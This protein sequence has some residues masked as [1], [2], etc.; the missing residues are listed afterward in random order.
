MLFLGSRIIER[1]EIIQPAIG[2]FPEE[3]EAYTLAKKLIVALPSA[4]IFAAALDLV[5]VVSYMKWI[6]PWCKIVGAK[7]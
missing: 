1:H 5:L 6:H 2:C 7:E 3:E 4:V